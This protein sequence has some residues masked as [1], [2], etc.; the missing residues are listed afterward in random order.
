M[1]NIQSTYKSP[2]TEEWLDVHFTR[3]I[4]YMW[5][6]FFKAL[7]IHPNVVTI[8]SVI[9]GIVA[10]VMFMHSDLYHNILGIIFLMWANFYDSCDGQLAR[11]TG[12]KTQWGRI[13]DGFAGD[14]WF[15]VIYGAIVVRLFHRPMPATATE[16][17]WTGFALCLI[18]GTLFHARQCQL[19]DYYRNIHLYFLPGATSE[20]HS[21][22]ALRKQLD[23][24]PC[25]GHFWW[26]I[27][28][29]A[30]AGYTRAQ[31][32]L[33]PH[34]QQLM[35]LIHTT[36]NGEVT[37]TF[38]RDFRRQSLPLMKYANIITFN[39]RAL[40]LY[41]TC[42]IDEPWLYPIAEMTLFA[43][44]AAYLR[45]R[46]ERMCAHFTEELNKGNY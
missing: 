29:R 3:P 27:F 11:L 12:K 23:A 37:E 16:W 28:L 21:S 46:H 36:R 15:F 32:R 35:N 44:I 26:R 2:D 25:K 14:V 30:Y 17:Q 45:H 6:L 5:T 7:D 1:P 8:L 19:A 31:E 43:A 42:L 10:G 20:L 24:T 4:G 33:T 22:V 38:R 39:C 9:L 34:F 18:S 41:I 13:L 40:T